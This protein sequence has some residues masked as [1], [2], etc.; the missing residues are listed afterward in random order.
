MGK[1][2]YPD[3]NATRVCQ[4]WKILRGRR[5]RKDGGRIVGG[6]EWKRTVGGSKVDK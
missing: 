2:F 3:K 4:V 5:G 6:G 1:K